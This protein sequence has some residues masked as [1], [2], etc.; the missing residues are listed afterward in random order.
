M[1]TYGGD[2]DR[3]DPTT[4]E[5][6]I[7]EFAV[8][9][10]GDELST[11]GLGSCV[12]IVL[13]DENAGVCGLAHVMLP[14]SKGNDGEVPGKYADTAVVAMVQEMEERGADAD[15][16][17]AKLVGGSEMFEFTGIAQGIGERNVKAAQRALKAKGIPVAA[18]DV[19]GDYGRSIRLNGETGTLTLK[20]A[21]NGHEEL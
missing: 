19:G 4:V 7:A 13:H 12:A 11:Y 14:N 6:G 9:D 17:Q 10:D 5:V 20:T 8:T 16:M 2:S 1:K 18:E 21:D 3:P 15:N